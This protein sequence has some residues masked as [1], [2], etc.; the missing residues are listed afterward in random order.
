M[1]YDSFFF[2]FFIKDRGTFLISRDG[3]AGTAHLKSGEAS[4]PQINDL[5]TD[6]ALLT[7]HFNFEVID[8][9]NMGQT[10][11]QRATAVSHTL[12]PGFTPNPSELIFIIW[13]EL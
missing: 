8:P 7:N 3:V 4:Y 6:C 2:F 5:I 11:E 12:G 1:D 13:R 9:C 10:L